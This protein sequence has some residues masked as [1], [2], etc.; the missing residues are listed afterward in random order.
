M[1]QGL[2]LFPPHMRVGIAKNEANSREKVTLTRTVAADNDIM[3][4]GERLNH[5]LILVAIHA[6]ILV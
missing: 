5:G 2:S 4:G 1:E 3:F 6:I